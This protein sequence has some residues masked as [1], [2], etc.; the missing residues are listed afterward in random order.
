[1]YGS[2]KN[3][4]KSDLFNKQIAALGDIVGHKALSDKAPNTDA[5]N[6]PIKTCKANARPNVSLPIFR[7]SVIGT[8]YKPNE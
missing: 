8:R 5:P 6:P 2:F 3:H 4:K 7:Y 1:M